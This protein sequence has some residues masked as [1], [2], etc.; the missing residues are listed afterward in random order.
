MVV[1]HGSFNVPPNGEQFPGN[2]PYN[3]I[4]ITDVNTQ[5]ADTRNM[6]GSLRLTY[7]LTPELKFVSNV[8]LFYRNYDTRFYVD[9]RSQQ[10]HSRKGYLSISSQGANTFTT[11]QTLTYNKKFL[12]GHNFNSLLGVEYYQYNRQNAKSSGEGF[13]SYEFRTMASAATILD[14]TETNIENKRAGI[15][16]Q[17][18]Y[19]Y[20]SKYMLSGVLRYDGSSRFGDDN[21]YG[22]FPAVSFGWDVARENFLKFSSLFQQLKLRASYGATGNSSISSYAAKALYRGTGSYGNKPGIQLYQLGNPDL[23]WEKNMEANIGLDYSLLSRRIFGSFDV[24]HRRSADLLLRRPLPWTSGYASVYQ[25]VG[26]VVNKGLEIQVT[27]VNI[28]TKDFKWT[29]DF[30]ITFQ[31]NRVTK[32][33][34]EVSTDDEEEESLSDVS[35]LPGLSSVRLGYSLQTNFRSQY[36]GV[37]PATGRP[38]WWYGNEK[39][40]YDPGGQ[41]ST[42]YNPHG[43]GN[44]LS[45]YYGGFI[46][47]FTYKRLELGIFFQYDM[48][49]ELYNSTNVRWYSG[50]SIQSNS[51]TRAYD[52]RW[53]EPGQMTAFP[54]PIDGSAE[55]LAKKSSI[56]SSRYLEDASYIRLKRV[57]LN[58]N[59]PKK[60]L[61]KLSLSSAKVY[62]EALNMLTITKWTGFDPE[63]YI[64]DDSN[65][66]SN[67]GQIPQA[68]AYTIGLSLNF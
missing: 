38:M 18:N 11:S 25:N 3:A 22:W 59:L 28:K 7:K 42:S 51:T 45:D 27:T 34:V 64:L 48:G 36:A 13:P 63:F 39:I 44:R 12:G 40:T 5:R 32:L 16:G 14:A 21:L 2:L 66:E 57:S 8:S 41:G 23:K 19:D 61:Q 50:G 30:N 52:Q 37:N 56:S 17:V 20:L 55:L 33:Y 6:S 9:P 60:F 47:T 65:F 26:E 43:R 29:T 35:S 68:R 15:F 46:N 58:Y 4:Q 53:T 49:R 10:G 54:R 31:N 62:A 24:F 1:I 67:L